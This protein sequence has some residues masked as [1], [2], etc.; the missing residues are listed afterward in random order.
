MLAFYGRL[1][2]LT[3]S[4]SLATIYRLPPELVYERLVAEYRQEHLHEQEDLIDD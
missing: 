3:I 2:Q 4:W 1:S